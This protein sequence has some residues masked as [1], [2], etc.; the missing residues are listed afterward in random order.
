[1][2]SRQRTLATGSVAR[3]Y[4][5]RY[6]SARR[7][8]DRKDPH[9]SWAV[10]EADSS[11]M[12]TSEAVLTGVIRRRPQRRIRA[13]RL[14]PLCKDRQRG[15]DQQN[16]GRLGNGRGDESVLAARGIDVLA[17]HLVEVI[18]AVNVN[19]YCSWEIDR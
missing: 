13:L 10:A 6:R 1:M 7:Y 3:E 5:L 16:R 4:D 11:A 8:L 12:L 17:D 9:H 15:H 18:Q 14:L 2:E 19:A